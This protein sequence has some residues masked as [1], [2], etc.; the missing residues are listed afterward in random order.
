M[1]PTSPGCS[2]RRG[3]IRSPA[4]AT[5]PSS[6]RS[7]PPGL[8]VLEVCGPQPRPTSDRDG[9]VLQRLGKGGEERSPPSAATPGTRSA[10][11]LD[12]RPPDRRGPR[13][14]AA[15]CSSTNAAVGPST[16]GSAGAREVPAAG[17]HHDGHAAHAAAQLRHAPARQRGGPAERPGAAR[18]PVALRRPRSTRTS[19]TSGCASS[20][21][22]PPAGRSDRGRAGG[23]DDPPRIGIAIGRKWAVT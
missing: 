16:R 2:T 20:S 5:G 1:R 9:G 23:D 17:L 19:R 6:K 18:P 22:R 21:H 10:D 13:P 12:A 3:R 7:T 14:A 11:W 4:G 15:R 8:R